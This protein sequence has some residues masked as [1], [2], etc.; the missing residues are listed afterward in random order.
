[1]VEQTY[2]LIP[3]KKTRLTMMAALEVAATIFC[4]YVFSD[5]LDADLNKD[6]VKE[7]LLVFSSW[8]GFTQW[9]VGIYAASETVVKGAES[10]MNK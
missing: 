10:G 2:K 9:N 3:S 8:A 5:M 6:Y 4:L 1:M 7:A